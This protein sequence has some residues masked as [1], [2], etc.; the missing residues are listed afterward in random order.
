MAMQVIFRYLLLLKML[1]E[2]N[3]LLLNQINQI[4]INYQIIRDN[5]C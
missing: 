1:Y 3:L 2:I 5:S 4:I